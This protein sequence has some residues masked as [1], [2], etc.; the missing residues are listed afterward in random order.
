MTA[1]QTHAHPAVAPPP[2]TPDPTRQAAA[3]FT[4]EDLA[5]LPDGAP[6]QVEIIDGVMWVSPSPSGNHQR[7]GM[8]LGGWLDVH[9]PDALVV[10]LAVGVQVDIRNVLEPDV[11]LLRRP[12]AG[13]HHCYPADQAVLAV[14]IVSPG[15]I[16]RD[17]YA[18][19]ALY[20]DAGIPHYWR[21][22]QED[23]RVHV[24]AY[25]IT[26]DGVYR[27]VADSAELLELVAPFKISLPV[28]AITP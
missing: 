16:K 22:E 12:Y 1:A 15:T 19:P 26:D 17:R 21:I 3:D 11:V 5:L 23:G 28:D 9:A 25:D 7:I 20:A 27:L 18:K 24:F 10:S 6:R 8:R 14:E 13:G 4:A 2:W